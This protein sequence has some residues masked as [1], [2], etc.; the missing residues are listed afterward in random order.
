[1]RARFPT[2]PLGVGMERTLRARISPVV[3]LERRRLSR[4][5]SAA[6]SA[7]DRALFAGGFA[8]QARQ[9]ARAHA[10]SGLP[11]AGQSLVGMVTRLASQRA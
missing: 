5:G 9:Q 1:M 7:P 6:R 3:D 11:L 2:R 8:G 4:M 10:L